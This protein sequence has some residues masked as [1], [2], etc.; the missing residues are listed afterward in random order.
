MN[1]VQ[2]LYLY[3]RI[4]LK[5]I[6]CWSEL[7]SNFMFI[8]M[9]ILCLM[10][11]GC[12]NTSILDD[13]NQAK[14]NSL[15]LD[16]EFPNHQY[17]SIESP[18]EIFELDDEMKIMVA[19]KIKPEKDSIKKT[20][21]LLKHIFDVENIALTYSSNA[22]VTAKQ[23]Y[24]QHAANCLSLTIMA[25]SLAKEADLNLNF[26][27]VEVPEYWVRNGQYSMLTGHVNLVLKSSNLENSM[28]NIV[29]GGNDMQI[30]FDPFTVKPYFNRKLISQH[31][32]LAMYYN[33]KA[34]Q[35]LVD[36]DYPKAYR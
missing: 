8:S 34:A 29:W 13:Y 32:V 3:Y 28:S 14:V 5:Q 25:Y 33:N 22:N 15:L 18:D 17:I 12:Q 19:Q 4:K 1:F 2:N 21:I 24:H 31:T 7:M 26:Q 20:K 23:A 36:L 16:N 30:D 10:I 35:A 11:T 9:F 27:E 6:I